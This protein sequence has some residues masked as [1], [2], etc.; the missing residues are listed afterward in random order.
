LPHAGYEPP[1]RLLVDDGRC[2]VRFTAEDGRASRE[3]DFARLP[4]SRELQL[5]FAG[6]FERWTGPSGTRRTIESARCA[7]G[8]LR[9]FAGFLAALPTPPRRPG[10]LAPSHLDSYVLQRRHLRS[11]SFDFL[12]VKA[13]LLGAA[14]QS[15]RQEGSR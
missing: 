10:D 12:A 4:V 3:F 6:G 14:Q 7:F 2:V 9:V 1:T 5:T 11:F 13:T 15:R 8:Y